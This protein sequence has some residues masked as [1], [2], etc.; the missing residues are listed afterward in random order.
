MRALVLLSLFAAATA[1]A[2]DE[3]T[4]DPYVYQRLVGSDAARVELET[5][6]GTRD[7]RPFGERGVEETARG[8]FRPTDRVEISVAGGVLLLG[9]ETRGDFAVEA[10]A[11]AIGDRT[12]GLQVGG[13][14]AYDFR[15][16]SLLR[17]RL[18]GLARVGR[19]D[20]VAS[21]L[22]EIPV[23]AEDRDE[24]DVMI[25]LAASTALSG[26]VRAGVEVLAEDIEGLWDD[27][28]AEGGARILA[29]PTLW[30]SLARGWDLRLSAGL[31]DDPTGLGFLGRATLGVAF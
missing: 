26:R 31:H 15:G 9:D 16:T 4:A 22:F 3:T 30:V 19:F 8:L 25:G 14:Y 17:A 23:G 10:M 18:A 24:V 27:E 29:A 5:A 11:L 13:G 21:A 28:E 1:F 2:D 7:M 20:L 12:L 6:V